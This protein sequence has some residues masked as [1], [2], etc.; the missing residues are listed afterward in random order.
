MYMLHELWVED[1]TDWTFCIAGPRGDAARKLL[2]PSAKLVWAVEAN[3]H[4]EAMT[5]YYTHMGW[6]EYRSDHSELDKKTYR[7]LE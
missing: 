5:L 2:S 4:F 1:E 7:E 6:G 3:N